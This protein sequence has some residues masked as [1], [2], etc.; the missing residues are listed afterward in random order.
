LDELKIKNQEFKARIKRFLDLS[1][2]YACCFTQL[3]IIFIFVPSIH[4]NSN[5]SMIHHIRQLVAEGN[6]QQAIAECRQLNPID[7]NLH[8][9]IDLIAARFYAYEKQKNV[10]NTDKNALESE[11]SQINTALLDIVNR[12]DALVQQPAPIEEVSPLSQRAETPPLEQ[13]LAAVEEMLVQ[14]R[15]VFAK[16]KEWLAV[17]KIKSRI[18]AWFRLDNLKAVIAVLTGIAGLI[19]CCFSLC[20]SSILTKTICRSR[21]ISPIFFSI[22]GF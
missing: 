19:T 12:L 2:K 11:W 1:L 13:P 7:A 21:T 8:S 5:E 18:I 3:K 20:G 14:K 4:R 15:S 6:I 17:H 16:F 9:E 10:G 22:T